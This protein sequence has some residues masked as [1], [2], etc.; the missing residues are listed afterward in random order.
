MVRIEEDL[1]W[2]NEKRGRSHLKATGFLLE[3]GYL[4]HHLQ[5]FKNY[6]DFP[7]DMKKW[8]KE[9]TETHACTYD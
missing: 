7:N 9:V 8:Y 4:P 6:H 2:S 3:L 1:S 5:F